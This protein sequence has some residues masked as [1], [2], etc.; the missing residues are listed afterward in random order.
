MTGPSLEPAPVASAG[1]GTETGSRV[2]VLVFRSDPPAAAVRALRAL[3]STPHVVGHVAGM[4]DLHVGS[5]VCV[6]TVFATEHHAIPA[7]LGG[8]LGCGIVAQRFDLHAPSLDRRT[9]RALLDALSRRIPVGDQAHPRA[10]APSL[11]EPFTT[12]PFSTHAL[13]RTRDRLGPQHLGTLGGGNHFVELDRDALGRIGGLEAIDTSD[14]AAAGWDVTDPELVEDGSVKLLV[15]KDYGRPS[16][17][18]PTLEEITG[19]DGPL[20]GLQVNVLDKFGGTKYVLDGRLVTEVNLA[21]FSDQGVAD[22]LDGLALGRSD[23]DLAAELKDNPGSL[24]LD[25]SV[26]MPGE[27][28][29]S[30]GERSEGTSAGSRVSWSADLTAAGTETALSATSEEKSGRAPQLVLVGGVLVLLAGA[31]LLIGMWASRRLDR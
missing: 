22:A 29:D 26:S 17:L 27:L 30:N 8:D 15:T 11:P 10:H 1:T 31:V 25:L 6:G 19:P 14:L 21:Q 28:I 13:V 12:A 9:L 4:A 16:D 5:G 24:T 7:A 20:Q 3:A 18:Q 23:K 2:P